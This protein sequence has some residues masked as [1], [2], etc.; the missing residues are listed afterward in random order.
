VPGEAHAYEL[1]HPSR[2]HLVVEV[3]D[4]TLIQD[5]LTKAAIYAGA[6]VAQYWI[7]NLRDDVIESFRAPDAFR[8]TYLA[9]ARVGRNEEITIDAF[10][11]VAV[12]TSRLLLRAR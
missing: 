12:A 10:P 7:V 8:R 11:G 5:R 2:A 6:S 9:S 1:S 3:A 4:S